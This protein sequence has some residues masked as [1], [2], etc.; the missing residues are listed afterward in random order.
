MFVRVKKIGADEYLYRVENAR[1]GGRHV[2]RVIKALGRREEVEA[3]GLIDGLIAAAARHSRR[4]IVLSSFY[5]GEL[6]ELPL[7]Q[8]ASAGTRRPPGPTASGGRW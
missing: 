5:R 2:Q 7:G 1:E 4:S 6:P 8:G 3:S